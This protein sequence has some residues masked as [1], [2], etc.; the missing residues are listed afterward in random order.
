MEPLRQPD[1]LVLH[2]NVAENWRRWKQQFTIFMTVTGKASS[3]DEVKCA[4]FLH[5]AGPDALEV[6]NT[7]TFAPGDEKKLEKVMEQFETYCQPRKNITR[8]RHIFNTRNQRPGESV[9]EYVTDLRGKAKSCEFKELT[10]SLIRDRLV[11]G[12]ISDKTRS[13]LL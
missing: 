8:E 12:I 4:I 1:P 11:C 6:F 3:D 2:G 13:R 9:D 5:L 7:L 10:E